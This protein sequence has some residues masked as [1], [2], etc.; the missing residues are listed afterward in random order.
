MFLSGV[1]GSNHCSDVLVSI[2]LSHGF[3]GICLLFVGDSS[4]QQALL[5]HYRSQQL[6]TRNRQEPLNHALT[7]ALCVSFVSHFLEALIKMFC[8]DWNF[9][10][11]RPG[12]AHIA[13]EGPEDLTPHVPSPAQDRALSTDRPPSMIA[14][15][16]THTHTHTRLLSCTYP[17]LNLSY[18]TPGVHL[19]GR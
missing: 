12:K 6:K 2:N 18:K 19:A 7:K 4:C 16:H 13:T 15:T 8:N 1:N 3:L 10:I 14:H 9:P 5:V 11:A 17:P